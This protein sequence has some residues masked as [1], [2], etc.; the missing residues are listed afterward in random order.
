[1][2]LELEMTKKELAK[3]EK[4]MERFGKIQNENNLKTVWC[5]DEVEDINETSFLSADYLTDGIHDAKIE[6]P[7]KELT[8]KE[9]WKAADE[10]YNLIGDTEH[11]FIE[12]FEVKEINGKTQL[13]VFFGS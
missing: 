11:R 12:A 7:N 3:F 2:N 1:M 6:L 9:L 5:I 8:Y 13:E 4:D 10:L